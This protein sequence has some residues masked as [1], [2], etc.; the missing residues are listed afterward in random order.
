M[1]FNLVPDDELLNKIE[2][3]NGITLYKM[4]YKNE[5]VASNDTTLCIYV[6]RDTVNTECVMDGRMST[7]ANEIAIDRM[8]GNCQLC[9]G[10][11]RY[12]YQD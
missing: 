5:T 10:F 8:Y 11:N 12:V 2:S 7:S 6:D 9:G 3:E 1:A 4:Y